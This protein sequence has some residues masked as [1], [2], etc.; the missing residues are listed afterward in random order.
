MFVYLDGKDPDDPLRPV[1]ELGFPYQT[2]VALGRSIDPAQLVRWR[3]R[4]QA[5]IGS[6]NRPWQWLC[7]S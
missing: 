2:V 7:Q 5:A 4:I 3:I 1:A 6:W